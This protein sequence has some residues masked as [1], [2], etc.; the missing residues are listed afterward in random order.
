MRFFLVLF[1]FINLNCTPKSNGIEDVK[2]LDSSSAST[3]KTSNDKPFKNSLTFLNLKKEPGSNVHKKY[4]NILYRSVQHLGLLGGELIRIKGDFIKKTKNASLFVV[5]NIKNKTGASFFYKR[6]NIDAFQNS[7]AISIKFPSYIVGQ[8]HLKIYIQNTRMTSYAHKNITCSFVRLPKSE[9]PKQ[10][11]RSCAKFDH[12]DSSNGIFQWNKTASVTLAPDTN[13]HFKFPNEENFSVSYRISLFEQG[14]DSTLSY[15]LSMD[16]KLPKRSN[17][18]LKIKVL[19]KA[20][21]LKYSK[22]INAQ[23]E[24]FETGVWNV[25]QEE[26][27]LFNLKKSDILSISV[28]NLTTHGFYIKKLCLETN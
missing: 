20:S 4:E 23:M 15:S 28:I 11:E 7:K 17:F 12:S 2:Y 18:E 3:N 22:T 16:F 24:G 8:D 26:N 21:D 10:K 27:Q 9:T 25:L 19:S 5:V 13:N 6:I 1:L 14:L